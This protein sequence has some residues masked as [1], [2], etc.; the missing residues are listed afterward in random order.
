[1]II[2]KAQLL[3]CEKLSLKWHMGF[4]LQPVVDFCLEFCAQERLAENT[5]EGK[6]CDAPWL[7]AVEEAVPMEFLSACL[8]FLI[9]GYLHL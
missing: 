4:T 1:M 2:Q 3:T 5:S 6:V 7:P 8:D 9:L